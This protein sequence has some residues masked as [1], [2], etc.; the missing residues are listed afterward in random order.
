MK[1]MKGK[2]RDHN[3]TIIVQVYEVSVI[4]WSNINIQQNISS[5]TKANKKVLQNRKRWI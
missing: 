2:K 5:I 3:L 4:W 1:S